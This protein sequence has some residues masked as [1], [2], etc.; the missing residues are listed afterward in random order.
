MQLQIL[1]WM[2]ISDELSLFTQKTQIASD[3]QNTSNEAKALTLCIRCGVVWW[4][5]RWD[6][7][8]QAAGVLLHF[9][10]HQVDSAC[11]INNK[12]Q[13]SIMPCH[14]YNVV[15]KKKHLNV[16]NNHIIILVPKL[17]VKGNCGNFQSTMIVAYDRK[18]DILLT[19]L[20]IICNSTSIPNKNKVAE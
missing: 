5:W 7:D 8:Q 9:H 13:T 4:R 11:P 18:E 10:W 17:V 16:D 15:A 12:R 1:H 2:Q 14:L 19:S 3:N 6:V 20:Q